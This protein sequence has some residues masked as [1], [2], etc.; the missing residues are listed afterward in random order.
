MEGAL[1]QHSGQGT[2]GIKQL[3]GVCCN[4]Q[5]FQT[6]LITLMDKLRPG[7]VSRYSIG[8]HADSN[9]L[10]W[11]SRHAF[12]KGLRSTVR[13]L[14]KPLTSP[15]LFNTAT[16]NEKHAQTTAKRARRSASV[17]DWATQRSRL[18]N[19][20]SVHSPPK[21]Q[22]APVHDFT[23]YLP[24]PISSALCKGPHSERRFVV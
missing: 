17:R 16:V 24:P 8:P 10:G 12:E 6:G 7:H 11:Q 2:R 3:P 21:G 19:S 5:S 18:A 15:K 23:L 14:L 22:A 1:G 13:W 20:H 4:D 9:E